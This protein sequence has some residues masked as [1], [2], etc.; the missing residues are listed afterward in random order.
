MV[1]IQS[2]RDH[3]AYRSV[4]A[5]SSA[6]EAGG[7]GRE[8]VSLK[9]KCLSMTDTSFRRRL[10]LRDHTLNVGLKFLG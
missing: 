2:V 1:V 10:K 4:S 8:F 5:S 6:V 7:L 9:K 3:L